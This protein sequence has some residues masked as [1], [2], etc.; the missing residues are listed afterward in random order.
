MADENQDR[1]MSREESMQVLCS[2]MNTGILSE[3][4][5]LALNDIVICIQGE[6]NGF[7]FWSGDDQDITDLNTAKRADTITDDWLQHCEKIANK[8]KYGLSPFE[9]ELEKKEAEEND[10]ED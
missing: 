10:D 4:V 2:L 7:H 1:M 9:I 5:E 3:D 6:I 8:Y